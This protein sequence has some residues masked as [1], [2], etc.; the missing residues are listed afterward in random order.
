ML[1]SLLPHR[2]LNR[3]FDAHPNYSHNYGWAAE[4]NAHVWVFDH[5]AED[6]N[7]DPVRVDRHMTGSWV[8][9][10]APTLARV[11]IEWSANHARTG[12]NDG[13]RW[14]WAY[15]VVAG[16]DAE[17]LDVDLEAGFD[18]AFQQIDQ[19]APA[20]ARLRRHTSVDLALANLGKGDR[21]FWKLRRRGSVDALPEP[22]L[23]F[24]L[25]LDDGL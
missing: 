13:V 24:G 5:R 2:D 12:P 17:S 6:A 20:S 11:H 4:H 15:K 19:A 1:H 23:L 21:L 3:G 10:V 14:Q 18:Q 7:G 16:D 25:F 8:V 22:A 9:P